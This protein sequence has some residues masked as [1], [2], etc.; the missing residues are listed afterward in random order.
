MGAFLAYTIYSGIFLLF[1]FLF[2]KLL[3]SGEKQIVLNRVLLLLCYAVS[4][5][6]WPISR[7]DWHVGKSESTH[8]PIV[9]MDN[10]PL[11]TLTIGEHSESIVPQILIWVYIFGAFVVLTSSLYS[12]LRIIIFIRQG[13]IVRYKGYKIVLIPDDKISPFSIGNY[14]VMSA[15]DY[16]TVG[17]TVTAHELAHIQCMHYIDLIIAQIVCVVVWY[18][19]ASWLMRDELKLLHE[20]QAD[21]KVIDR[22]V[23]IFTYQM[24]L[25]KRAVGNRFNTLS[26][27]LNHSKLKDRIAMMQKEKSSGVSRT[28]VFALIIAPIVPLG[29]MNI[30]T[31]AADLKSLE[32]TSLQIDNKS[33]MISDDSPIMEESMLLNIMEKET[34]KDDSHADIEDDGYKAANDK[35]ERIIEENQELNVDPVQ[36]PEI[37]AEFPGGIEKLM[38]YLSMN[39]RYPETAQVEDRTGKSVVEFT[40]QADGA[41]SDISILE[42][43]WPDLDEEAMRVVKTMPKW[44]PATVGGNAVVSQL[45]IPITFRLQTK[46]ESMAA[47]QIKKEETYIKLSENGSAKLVVGPSD[48]KECDV[49]EMQAYRVD[50][51]LLTECMTIDMSDIESY[52]IFPPSEEFPGGLCDIKLKKK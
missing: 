25:I 37:Q 33:E 28:R 43:S 48:D 24:L 36:D 3:V 45:S 40:V 22:G 49:S 5:V 18:N 8:V 9:A 27:S 41:V 35:D 39:I 31:V 51:K 21:A 2:Y 42:S 34:P 23:D 44:K 38:S 20:Y 4:F 14:I 10:L 12:I 32:S 30:P 26:N 1:L 19:P 11:Q 50:G 29:I 6:A 7:I 17:D 16:E 15:K 13:E 46:E 47:T 52:K